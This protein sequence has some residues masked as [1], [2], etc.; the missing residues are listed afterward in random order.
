MQVYIWEVDIWFTMHVI[1]PK[2]LS[3][4]PH[5]GSKLL[6]TFQKNGRERQCT[7]GGILLQRPWWLYI[8][9]FYYKTKFTD[10]CPQCNMWLIL[11]TLNPHCFCTQLN[12]DSTLSN[13]EDKELPL[14]QGRCSSVG[15]EL[16]CRAGWGCGFDSQSQTKY[17]LGLIK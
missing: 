16:D 10:L 4:G 7:L 8:T 6:S 2:S 3:G 12:S 5:I 15:R 17:T 13:P 9:Y 11:I 14:N 1:L